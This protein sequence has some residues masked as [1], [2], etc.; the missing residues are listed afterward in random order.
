MRP[1]SGRDETKIWTNR[2]TTEGQVWPRYDRDL[3]GNLIDIWIDILIDILSKRRRLTDSNKFKF[4][5]K[6]LNC[7]YL[8]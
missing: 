5:M 4:R 7:Q 2:G 3:V 1:E 8:N 6:A